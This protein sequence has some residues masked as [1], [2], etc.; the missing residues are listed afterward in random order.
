VVR[1]FINSVLLVH[2]SPWPSFGPAETLLRFRFLFRVLESHAMPDYVHAPVKIPQSVMDDLNKLAE[3]FDA[4]GE[5]AHFGHALLERLGHEREGTGFRSDLETAAYVIFGKGFK[6]FHS[7]RILCLHGCGADAL[8]LCGS[9]FENLV[10]LLYIRQ[11]PHR[12]RNYLTFE[13]VDKYYQAKKVLGRPDLPEEKKETYEGYLHELTPQVQEFLSMFPLQSCW[14]KPVRKN[15]KVAKVNLRD[16]AEAVGFGVEYATLYYIFCGHKHT[17]PAAASGFMFQHGEGVDVIVG[18]N[19]KGVHAA[20]LHSAI[21]FLDLC[22]V[23]QDVYG[24]GIE[25]EVEILIQKVREAGDWTIP[26]S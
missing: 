4:T 9:L 3:L 22:G 23:F 19:V 20:A 16:R 12:A 2:S 10:D 1:G 8:A 6:T 25:T 26:G 11:D 18:P 14:C 15:S 13:Q 24:L 7:V 21:Y 17:V 5:A